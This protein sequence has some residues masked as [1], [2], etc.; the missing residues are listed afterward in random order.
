MAVSAQAATFSFGPQTGKGAVSTSFYRHRALAVD[1]SVIDETRE[2][3]AEVGGLAVPTFPY[4]PGPIVG[5]G[6]S[7]QPRMQD[8]FGWLLYAALGKLVTSP[9]GT[10]VPDSVVFDGG[11][12][13]LGPLTL[14]GDPS[15]PSQLTVKVSGLAGGPLVIAI[16]G[17][18][19]SDAV[20]Y[21]VVALPDDTAKLTTHVFKTVTSINIGVAA[22]GY[23]LINIRSSTGAPFNHKF[24]LDPSDSTFIPW[25]SARKQLPRRNG[26]PDTDLGEIYQDLKVTGMSLSLAN[27]A[28]LMA[29][30]DMLGCNFALDPSP[31]AWSYANAFEDWR[32]VPVLCHTVGKIKISGV[33]LPVVAAQLSLQN[34][35]L[36][37]RQERVIGRSEEHTS[38]LQSLTNLVCR[39]L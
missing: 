14:A 20:I 34:V 32:S 29:R 9:S 6:I 1:L 24:T 21:E 22:S 31:D 28:P 11:A 2:G 17:T 3:Q 37:I 18:D 33:D 26:D 19:P 25:L 35:P 5:G 10:L 7:L 4:K 30:M 36:D 38:E 27:D 15:E 16:A 23:G 39:L 13:P 8:T 12:T